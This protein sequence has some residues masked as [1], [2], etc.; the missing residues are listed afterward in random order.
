MKT[1]ISVRW[2]RNCSVIGTS[3]EFVAERRAQHHGADA[4]H[5]RRAHVECRSEVVAIIEECDALVAERTHGRERAAEPDGQGRANVG[6]NQ[7][8]AGG[9]TDD[10]AEQERTRDVDG[11]G[12]E[13]KTGRGAALDPSLEAVARECAGDAAERD[14]QDCQKKTPAMNGSGRSHQPG[15]RRLKA[16]SIACLNTNVSFP[17]WR[18]SA[19]HCRSSGPRKASTPTTSLASAPWLRRRPASIPNLTSSSFPRRRRRAISSKAESRSSRLPPAR[20]RAI[21]RPRTTD[22]RST[23]PWGSTSASRI[24]STTPRSTLRSKRGSTTSRTS[25]TSCSCPPRWI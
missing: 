5:N 18:K 24:I 25:T 16:N 7:R 23:S 1:R 21:S 6:R 3:Q 15:K 10:E 20:W 4:A 8:R 22:R 2:P 9:D 12:S 19:S 14:I 13:R 11:D 17:P